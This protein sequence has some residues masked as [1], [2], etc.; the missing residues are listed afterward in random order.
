MTTYYQDGGDEH[1][2][3]ELYNK[4]VKQIQR[5]IGGLKNF[6]HITENN[7]KALQFNYLFKPHA[8]YF[9]KLVGGGKPVYANK[10]YS[11]I[12]NNQNGGNLMNLI[13]R[14][15]DFNQLVNDL[16]NGG[17]RMSF[18]RSPLM[19]MPAVIPGMMTGSPAM[20]MGLGFPAKPQYD[21]VT[22]SPF[23]EMNPLLRNNGLD[24]TSPVS[25]PITAMSSL[26][27]TPMNAA[28]DSPMNPITLS[29]AMSPPPKLTLG[30]GNGM[31]MG[32]GMG[33][34][35]GTGMGMGPVGY[36]AMPKQMFSYNNY[37]NESDSLDLNLLLN[38]SKAETAG[39]TT[40]TT[41]AAAPAAPPAA[42]AAPPA[43]PAKTGGGYT[44]TPITRSQTGQ[45]TNTSIWSRFSQ[46]FGM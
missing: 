32:T 1:G 33:M 36:V 5:Q 11:V 15:G 25:G 40:G 20:G 26:A 34:G 28:P 12:V 13:G 3:I 27:L 9:A 10:T 37:T 23:S 16:Q 42:P 19:N 2:N 46:W 39:T 38:G 14:F 30:Y 21:I 41:T 18:M 4:V 8:K 29:K 24:P 22:L 17:S 6:S 45:G 44:L 35:M 31:S 43:A 7:Q